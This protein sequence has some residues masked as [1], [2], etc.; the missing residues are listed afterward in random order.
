MARLSD[1]MG[2]MA[3]LGDGR[4]APWIRQWCGVGFSG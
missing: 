4:I 3:G 1:W 2:D